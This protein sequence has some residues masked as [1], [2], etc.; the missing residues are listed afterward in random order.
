MLKRQLNLHNKTNMFNVKILQHNCARLQNVM[1]SLL[2]YTV[3]NKI[4]IVI[5]QKP[6]YD[7]QK[8]MTINHSNFQSIILKISEIRLRVVTYIAKSNQ[9][10]QCTYRTDLII[11]SDLQ[12]LSISNKNIKKTYLINVYNKRKQNSD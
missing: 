8:Q 7:I 9:D 3:L 2:Q 12:I 11:D 6:Y 1:V 10:L 4:D 5:I